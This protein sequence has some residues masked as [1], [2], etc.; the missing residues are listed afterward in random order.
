[1][2]L[3]ICRDESKTKCVTSRTCWDDSEDVIFPNFCGDFED[4]L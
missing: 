2:I 4:L 1:M 3:K